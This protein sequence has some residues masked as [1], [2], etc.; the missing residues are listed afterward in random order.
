MN[1]IDKIKLSN[2]DF[3]LSYGNGA[4]YELSRE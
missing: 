4:V 3:S 1:V 2:D